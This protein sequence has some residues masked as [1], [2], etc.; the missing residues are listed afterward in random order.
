MTTAHLNGHHRKTLDR[1]FTHPAPHN[2]EWHDVISLLNHLGTAT[3]RHGGGYNVAIGAESLILA[4]P[5]GHDV[6]DDELRHLSGF[7]TN[8][9][10]APTGAPPPGEPGLSDGW[11]V[12]I[13]HQQARLFAPGADPATPLVIRPDDGDGSRRRLEHRQGNDDHDGGHASEDE[14]YY[15]RIAADLADAPRIVVLS[16]GKGR[17]NAGEYLIAYVQRHFPALAA[18]IVASGTIDI[19][20]TSDGEAVAAGHALLIAA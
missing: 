18:R 4:R 1:I 12:L 13:D 10:L 11:V 5:H 14:G 9:G 8:A 17:A 15:R 19:S 3:E 16:N 7:L 2:I 20:K 6:V